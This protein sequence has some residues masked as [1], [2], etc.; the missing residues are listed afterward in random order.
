MKMILQKVIASS[1]YCSRRKAEDMINKGQ[2]KVNGEKA[3]PG[4]QADP[5]KDIILIK[6]KPLPDI[7][8]K[9]YIRLNKPAGYTCT[10]RKFP[11][12]KNIFSL[13]QVPQRLFAIGRLDKDSRGLIILTNDGEL[14]QMLAHPKFK[15]DK[16]YQ[17]KVRGEIRHPKVF[18]NKLMKGIDIGDGDGFV[19]PKKALYQD[20]G[21]FLLTLEEGKKRQI[22]RMFQAMN[23]EI[24]DLK[25]ISFGKLGVG[26]IKEGE[27]A[28]LSKHELEKLKEK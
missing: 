3:T 27:W 6:N 12:E 15:H 25:R 4:D 9:V 8:E 1:G 18:L 16:V 13:V 22:R 14:T 21:T 19:S 17:V 28:Y 24:I 26:G 23:L 5:E 7:K 11:G 2:V 20:D 10:N